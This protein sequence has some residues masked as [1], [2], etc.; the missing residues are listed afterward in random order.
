MGC[1]KLVRQQPRMMSSSNPDR[2]R[3]WLGRHPLRAS[4]RIGALVLGVGATAWA[5]GGLWPT[6]DQIDRAALATANAPATIAPLPSGPI[7]LLVIGADADDLRDLSNQAAPQG[8]ANA[9]VIVLV[10]ISPSEPLQI[11]QVPTELAVKTPDGT[12]PV[13]LGSLWQRGGIALVADSLREIIGL[14]EAEPQRYVVTP[15]RVIRDLIDGLGDLDV[16]L[17][18]AYARNDRAQGFVVQLQAGRQRLNGQQS[19]QL[20]RYLNNPQ[21]QSNRRSRQQLVIQAVVDQLKSASGLQ[22]IKQILT[23]LQTD[24]DSN[25]TQAELLSLTAAVMAS[26]DVMEISQLSLE[27]RAGNQTLRQLKAGQSL[28][29]WPN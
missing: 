12:M 4:L 3:Q 25:L 10:R 29:L 6:P 21:D 17:P 15:R 1:D 2:V 27:P 24:V 16:T 19:E 14:D 5:L 22:R 9:D 13:P 28:P 26:P 8:P 23:T 20:L 11:L 7:T 18:Q